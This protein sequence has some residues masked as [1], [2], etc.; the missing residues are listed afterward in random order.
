M[1]PV[2]SISFV[3]RAETATSFLKNEKK[4][5]KI[6]NKS[7]PIFNHTLQTQILSRN[8]KRLIIKFPKGINITNIDTNLESI[9]LSFR[10][11][12]PNLKSGFRL[13]RAK[14]IT[15]NDS[16]IQSIFATDTRPSRRWGGPFINRKTNDPKF[17]RI[18][19]NS[20]FSFENFDNNAPI[21][22][23][24]ITIQTKKP[25][26]HWRSMVNGL[27]LEGKGKWIEIDWPVEAYLKEDTLFYIEISKGVEMVSS[28]QII[29]FIG[30][31]RLKSIS[32]IPNQSVRL[33]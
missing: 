9:G 14:K 30:K 18:Q 5:P 27:E 1:R 21:S 26:S 3:G 29:P 33:N 25:F 31:R 10:P 17:E 20:L 23:R 15:R 32:A 28:M 11:T 16:E 19:I 12:N 4:Q 2:E 6:S 7:T 13:Q 8:T 22:S 24:G